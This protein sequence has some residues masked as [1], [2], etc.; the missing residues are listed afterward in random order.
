MICIQCLDANEQRFVNKN[1]QTET[2]EDNWLKPAEIDLVYT[3]IEKAVKE[4]RV[5]HITKKD[6]GNFLSLMVLSLF[7]LTPPRRNVDYTLM[8]ISNDM[9]DLKY[10]YLDV[11]KKSLCI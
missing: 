5:S 8:K 10:N 9:T 11:D 6:F 4:I 2:Q 3:K 7:T 1:D